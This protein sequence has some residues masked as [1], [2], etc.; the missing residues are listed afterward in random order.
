MS[1][2][3]KGRRWPVAEGDV[4]FADDASP[5][6]F[7]FQTLGRDPTDTPCDDGVGRLA[8]RCPKT[9]NPCGEIIVGRGQMPNMGCPT[10]KWD[11]NLDAPTLEP[12]INCRDC[13]HGYLR[14]GVFEEC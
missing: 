4:L 9:G 5:G 8:Y 6:D 14:A 3:V 10:W 13:W 1:S 11:G 7:Q 12:S 2:R